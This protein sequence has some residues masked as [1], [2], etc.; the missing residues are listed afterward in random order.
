M[1]PH[2]L[3][4]I[5]LLAAA[6]LPFQ[7]EASRPERLELFYGMAEGNYLIGD[8]QGAA[9]GLEEVLRIN[10]DYLPALTLKARVMLDQGKGAA[11]LEAARR[12]RQLVPDNLEYALLEALVLGNLNRTEAATVIIE[13]VLARTEPGSDDF[14]AAQQL[15]GL[16]RMAAQDWEAAA[17]AFHRIYQADPKGAEASLQLVQE[18]Y[19]EKAR[20]H[21]QSGEATAAIAAVNQAIALYADKTGVESLRQRTALHMMRARIHARTGNFDAAIED[22][23]AL[24]GQDP[25]NLEATITLAALYASAERWG[26]LEGLLARIAAEPP[27]RDIALY[28]EGRAALARGRV[29]TARNKFEQ[30]LELASDDST[31]LRASLHFYR[32]LCLMQLNRQQEADTAILEALDLG[33]LPETVDE[34]LAA[35]RLLLRIG[36][37]DRAIPILE[38]ITL[39]RIEPSARIWAML[40]RAHRAEGT[41]TL[42][43]SAFNESLAIDRNQAEVRALRGSLLRQIGDLEGAV[44]DYTAALALQPE[45]GELH[46]ALGLVEFQRGDLPTARQHFQKA[47]TGMPDRS[48]VHLMHAL[49]AYATEHPEAAQ[50]ALDNHF[51]LS[52]SNPNETAYLLEYVLAKPADNQAALTTLQTRA[53]RNN[54]SEFLRTYARY[55]DDKLDQK[56][57]LDAAGKADT[58]ETARRQLCQAAFWMAQHHHL[59]RETREA[60]KLL[61][62]ALDIGHPDWP[63]HQ[64]A[65]WQL[66]TSE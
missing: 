4:Q 1:L 62:I 35:C 36:Q 34:A 39:N 24:T 56:S 65:H 47:A 49:L 31:Q 38:A 51:R 16:L 14:K 46:Y 63:E 40:G 21:L 44:A 11:A 26:S 53:A 6:L 10:P 61:K 3:F 13:S 58:P 9:S 19:V 18:A 52:D 37:A 41:P 17:D 8:L 29:G 54:A 28:L 55:A 45:N 7:M 64:L 2:R 20:S 60:E 48:G 23:Q 57:M 43:L 42:A 12:A 5:A 30:A 32:G 59:R 22:L 15:L 33:F 66:R 25:D 50:S 27:L